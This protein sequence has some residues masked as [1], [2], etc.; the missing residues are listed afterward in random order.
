[1]H[2]KKILSS[3]SSEKSVSQKLTLLL[4]IAFVLALVLTIVSPLFYSWGRFLFGG[5]T[6]QPFDSSSLQKYLY[7]WVGVGNG[8]YFSL[9]YFPI[10]C[11]YRLFEFFHLS[12]LLSSYAIL[13]GINIISA[14]GVYK[15][16]KLVY[17]PKNDYL[18]V[19]P[20][21][22]YLLSPARLNGWNYMI[23]YAF[24]PIF[25]YFVFKIVIK[26]NIGY[27]DIILMN[28]AIAFS[29]LDLPNPKYLFHLYLI[30]FVVMGMGLIVGLIDRKFIRNNI[31]KAIL[32][33]ALSAYIILPQAYFAKNYSPTQY[34]V[35]TQ[36]GYQD[37]GQ[38]MDFGIATIDKMF[39]LHHDNI[40]LDLAQKESYS[41][42]RVT[43]IAG[44]FFILL[45]IYGCFLDKPKKIM[46]T[47]SVVLSLICIYLYF[48]IGSN[49][50]TGGW[51]EY[52][53]ANFALLAFLRT[54]VG[55]V[56]YLSLF[57]SVLLFGVL[58]YVKKNRALITALLI[59]ALVVSSY[60]IILGQTYLNR[61]PSGDEEIAT[62][63]HGVDIPQ[64]YFDVAA[65]LSEKKLDA[66]VLNLKSDLS[67]ISNN[68]GYFGI[69]PYS[70]LQNNNIGYKDIITDYSKH[71]VAFLY[72]DKSIKTAT[73]V[74][75]QT[76]DGG[77][78]IL[79][80]DFIDVYSV[81]RA[82]FLPHIYV[83][84]QSIVA[85]GY[86][87]D[88]SGIID[89]N[90]LKARSAVFLK[91]QNEGEDSA[92]AKL[93]AEIKNAPVIEYRKVNPTKYVLTIHNARG[94]FPVIF[95]EAYNRN[96]N[97]YSRRISGSV[98][99]TDISKYKVLD[100]NTE[101]QASVVEIRDFIKHGYVSELGTQGDK[102]ILHY[103]WA[104]YRKTVS[105]KEKY[106]IGFVSKNFQ[107]TIQN[108]NMS[109]SGALNSVFKKPEIDE[110]QHLVANGY[111]NSWVISTD[112]LCISDNVCNKNQDGTY[113]IPL[114]LEF[115]PQLIYYVSIII[116][117]AGLICAL[118]LWFVQY[119]RRKK[120][121]SE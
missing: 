5:D 64:G 92:L 110:S 119:S 99:S 16:I 114:T 117:L 75:Y 95:S 46:M 2:I 31:M 55:A 61:N 28:V 109:D 89:Q 49:P 33:F 87:Q 7:Q 51:Y 57:Y 43:Y 10:F 66:K 21:I 15:L 62:N 107:G 6:I 79:S 85:D 52:F 25:V 40:N 41:N 78:K 104:N 118:L 65:A 12:A 8:Q 98:E 91:S 72:D 93:V 86:P 70:Y 80:K 82:N 97:I 50:P 37:E 106:N 83:P 1:M 71:N 20:I 45:I 88:V 36:D 29:S 24:I 102:T 81:D 26:K 73:N 44:A 60:P 9:S 59:V 34:G 47:E 48:A 11:L 13:L 100:G 19:F 22:F 111:S 103:V 56:F 23:T 101:D 94:V 38:M 30:F 3:E 54:T 69:S 42:K 27:L 17:Q 108:D 39:L 105:Y 77:D 32:F 76:S 121:T 96:W 112:S 68:W 35:H 113:D 74:K 18:L 67:Y 115:K 84:T 90:Q 58:V 120:K 63:S 116:S 14:I 53:V 4:N